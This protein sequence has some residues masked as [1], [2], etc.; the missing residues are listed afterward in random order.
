LLPPQPRKGIQIQNQTSINVEP[1]P[2]LFNKIKQKRL[3]DINLNVGIA[4]EE[5]ELTFYQLDDEDS[6]AGS[7]FDP[8]V[9]EGLTT[10]GYVISKEVKM[11]VIP[12]GK[13]LNEN[14]NNI[15]VDFMSVDTEGFDLQVLKS[16]DWDKYRP[17]LILVETV[18]NKQAIYDYMNQIGYKIMFKNTT[19]TLFK[20]NG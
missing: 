12:L 9:A 3:R 14:L 17:T 19:N 16:N 7:T 13:A 2:I 5:S 20:D 1:H 8:Q 11:P 4:Q 15:H 18:N 6:R 10:K